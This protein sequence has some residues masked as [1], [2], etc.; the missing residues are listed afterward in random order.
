MVVAVAAGNSGPGLY[1]VESPGSAA[2]ALTAGASTVAHFIGV[3]GD[4]RRR[5][6]YGIAAGDFAT[7]AAT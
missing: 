1:T 5:S 6:A 2:R 7:V 3:A 4:R